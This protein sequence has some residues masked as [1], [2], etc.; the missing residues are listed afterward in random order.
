MSREIA[1]VDL[2][3]YVDKEDMDKYKDWTCYLVRIL[4]DYH[5]NNVS[6]YIKMRNIPNLVNLKIAMRDAPYKCKPWMVREE[7]HSVTK[8]DS[9]DYIP[10]INEL[11]V[12]EEYLC[13]NHSVSKCE[14]IY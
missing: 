10:D 12:Y 14:V 11:W 8:L 6:L 3:K 9:E 5:N 13:E 1:R 7:I 2:L 4:S